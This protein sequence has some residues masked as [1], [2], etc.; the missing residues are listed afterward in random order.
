LLLSFANGR[1]ALDFEHDGTGESVRAAA[2]AV[3]RDLFGDVPEPIG[4]RYWRWQAEKWSAGCYSYPAVGS[5]PG[6]RALYAR[7]LADRVF[8]AGEATERDSYGTV[9]A[10]LQSGERAAETLLRAATGAAPD[11]AR[12][13]WRFRP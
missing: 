13:P 2:L 7:P 9:H 11:R 5:P 12:R 8:F 10:A 1:A 4:M 3:L 6:D